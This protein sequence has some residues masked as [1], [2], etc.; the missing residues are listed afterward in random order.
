ML[1]S[2][3]AFSEATEKKR[4][5][6]K[7]DGLPLTE[8]VIWLEETP[9]DARERIEVEEARRFQAGSGESE[10]ESLDVPGEACEKEA[11]ETIVLSIGLSR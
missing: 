3:T 10:E 2:P 1:R 8:V 5:E 9:L 4:A 7:F 6:A 11:R